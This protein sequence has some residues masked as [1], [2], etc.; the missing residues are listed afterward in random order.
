MM[1]IPLFAMVYLMIS[2]PFAL[3][4]VGASCLL[5]KCS[6][7]TRT[8]VL[9]PLATLLF[10]PGLGPATIAIV[11]VPFG[12][13]FGIALVSFDWG[14]LV[15]VMGLAPNYWYFITFP[16]TAVAAYILWKLALSN[17]SS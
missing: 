13:L 15:E 1:D 12:F 8:A 3:I 10:T 4:W 17:Q 14:W 7:I 6:K 5:G 9:V 11:P 16:A 2:A